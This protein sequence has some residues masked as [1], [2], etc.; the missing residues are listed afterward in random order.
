V[1]ADTIKPYNVVFWKR[2]H[3]DV[4]C[5]ELVVIQREAGRLYN[6]KII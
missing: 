2:K 3:F 5:N 4:D 6:A 1:D